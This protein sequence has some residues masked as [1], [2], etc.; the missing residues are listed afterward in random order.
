MNVRLMRVEG[1]EARSD[2]D[3]RREPRFATRI[4]ARLLSS[5]GQETNVQ[6]AEVS[7]HGCR[8]TI[9]EPWLRNGM[10]V[11]IGLG[12]EPMLEAI[13]RWVRGG[14][15]GMEFLWP[16]PPERREWHELADM[17]F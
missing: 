7:L 4:D 16:I 10:F 12:D 3:R 14:D 11:S 8:I 1:M 6:L 13:V 9:S 15:A 17:A 2:T 5:T